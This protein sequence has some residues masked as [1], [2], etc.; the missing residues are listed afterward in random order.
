MYGWRGRIG[1]LVPSINT[2]METEFWGLAPHGVSVHTARIAGGREG[3]PETLRG[4]EEASKVAA[5]DVA[6]VEPDVVVYGCTSGSFFEGPS[7]NKKICEQLTKI[8][9]APTVT[10]AGAMVACLKA[11]GHKKVDVVTPYVA[12]TNERLKSFLKVQGITVSQLG[13]FDM[14]DMFDHAKIEPEEIYRKV[15]SMTTDKSEA[16]FVA[17]TQLRA[18]EVLDELERDLGKPVYSAVQASAWQAFDIMGVDPDIQ[19]GGSL[20]RRLSEPKR[21]KK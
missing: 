5:G 10:T 11:G 14:L 9:K 15:K 16:V 2:T 19:D 4:M 3:T 17:C 8:T 6:M 1:L 18:L 13:T 7:W 20:L 21:G 12:L